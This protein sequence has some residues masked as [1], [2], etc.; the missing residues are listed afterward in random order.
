MAYGLLLQRRG[1]WL[2]GG[3]FGGEPALGL[4]V[5]ELVRR[6]FYPRRIFVACE[7]E[8]NAAIPF[9]SNGFRG[10]GEPRKKWHFWQS[11]AEGDINATRH[12]GTSLPPSGHIDL[13]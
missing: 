13:G 2:K 1:S 10:N 6:W 8:T 4:H 3:C 5:D 7:S 11:S 12:F 9:P